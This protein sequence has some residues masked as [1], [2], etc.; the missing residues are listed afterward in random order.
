MNMRTRR[1]IASPVFGVI[2]MSQ[3]LVAP[4]R[5]R[6]DIERQPLAGNAENRDPAHARE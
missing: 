1:C 4:M 6:Q 5:M 2:C 3:T